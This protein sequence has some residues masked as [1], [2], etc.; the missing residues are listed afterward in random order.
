MGVEMHRH[1]LTPQLAQDG[2]PQ[3]PTNAAVAT[4]ANRAPGRNGVPRL[5]HNAVAQSR[6]QRP[7]GKQGEYH[8]V[9]FAGQ[10]FAVPSFA[11]PVCLA[12]KADRSSPW[13]FSASSLNELREEIERRVSSGNVLQRVEEFAGHEILSYGGQLYLIHAAGIAGFLRN[14]QD[15]NPNVLVAHSL[16][17]LRRR[18][19]QAQGMDLAGEVLGTFE[20]YALTRSNGSVSAFPLNMQGL[21]HLPEADRAAAGVIR[22]ETRAEVERAIRNQPPPR[23]V[24]FTGW[25]PAFQQFGN[26][27]KH[28]QFGHIDVPPPGY[29]F[30]QSPRPAV[31]GMAL[32]RL[33]GKAVRRFKVHLAQVRLFSRCLAGGA[34]AGETI[35]FLRTRDTSSQL[36][37]PRRN[38]LLFL[39]SIPFTLGQ[40][41]WIIEVEDLVTLLFPYVAN[42]RTADLNVE[43]QP[44]FRAVRALL[45]MPS[46]RAIITHIRATAD[47]IPTLFRSQ[48]IA[49]KTVHVPMGVRAPSHWQKH[50]PSP[51]VNLLFTNSWHQ[52]AESF[53]LRGGLEVLEAFAA[54]HPAYPELRLTL[55]TKLPR[56][57]LPR[58]HTIIKD[59]GVTVLDEFLPASKLEDLLL[60]SHVFLL[61]SA[62]IHIMSVLQAMA[63]GLVPVVSDGWGMSEYVEHGKTGLIAGGRYGKVSW[64]DERNGMLREDYG[65]MHRC[66]PQVAQHV[67]NELSRLADDAELRRELGRNAR[68]AVERQFSLA[69]WNSGLKQVLDRAWTGA[70]T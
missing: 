67:V 57:L 27:G 60:S 15:Q 22:G 20:G 33:A 36:A 38:R 39:T 9:E 12:D 28:P 68:R 26:C 19:L 32:R 4:A 43:E 52:N 29:A 56:D 16:P 55:R 40:D 3:D 7:H 31:P 61:P 24:E 37:L 47:G 23:L 64:N 41:P 59:G 48:A 5:Q 6:L 62:R 1:L 30:V 65:P 49:R 14:G 17:E 66:D 25:L 42:G 8:L 69:R 35:D 44:G 10:F 46:C 45:E 13:I 2:G 70:G 51:T 63:Y 50:E 54:L 11:A 34:S 21:E 18:V 53:Y 58:C